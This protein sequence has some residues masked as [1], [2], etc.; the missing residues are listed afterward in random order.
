MHRTNW[1]RGFSEW[2]G[3][4]L[5]EHFEEDEAPRICLHF[6]LCLHSALRS[7]H[8]R[9]R[10]RSISKHLEATA[11]HDECSPWT[12]WMGASVQTDSFTPQILIH[13]YPI[14]RLLGIFHLSSSFIII[15]HH[16]SH[17]AHA[18]TSISSGSKAFPKNWR[19]LWEAFATLNL[20]TLQLTS[21]FSL[22]DLCSKA[23]TMILDTEFVSLDWGRRQTRDSFR[24]GTWSTFEYIWVHEHL[25]YLVAYNF[26]NS[27]FCFNDIAVPCHESNGTISVTSACHCCPGSLRGLWTYHQDWDSIEW[28][29]GWKPMDA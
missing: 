29:S 15:Y 3:S 17:G 23:G 6:A 14:E 25:G 12:R 13:S 8:G 27:T 4:G 2:L 1:T 16:L 20:C 7:C 24:Q 5:D 11:G 10:A 19:S 18:F 21:G 26:G 9:C 22:W 28:Y